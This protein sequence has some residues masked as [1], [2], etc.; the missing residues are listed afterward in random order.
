[1]WGYS[2]ERVEAIS[3][4]ITQQISSN[5]LTFPVMIWGRRTARP[6][7]LLHG[8]PQEPSTWSAVAEV[9]AK[10]GFQAIAPFQRGYVPTASPRDP[11]DYT[12]KEFVR[13]ALGIADGLG[14]HHFDVVGFGIGGVQAWM[15]AA[16]NPT[17]VRSLTSIRFPHPAA[18]ARTLRADA[19]QKEKWTRLQQDLGAG[20]PVEKAEAMLAS[21]A[22]GLRRF[23]SASGLPQPFLDRYVSRLREPGALS[24]ALYWNLAISLDIFLEVPPVHVATLL[25]WSEGPAFARAAVE[26][27]AAYVQAPFTKALVLDGSHFLLETSPTAVTDLLLKHLRVT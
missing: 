1:M 21:D 18:F 12:F 15:I 27:S 2:M 8:F 11:H 19:E 3:S 24:G 4:P 25:I 20:N 26:A 23:L 22:A 7:L 14:L 10:D 16:T 9:L 17:R 13:D 5:G 6:V